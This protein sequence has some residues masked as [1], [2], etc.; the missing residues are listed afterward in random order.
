MIGYLSYSK[1]KWRYTIFGIT[2]SEKML[3]NSVLSTACMHTAIATVQYY[4]DY[5]IVSGVA[6]LDQLIGISFKSPKRKEGVVWLY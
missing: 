4:I 2:I 3:Y 1:E 5:N 6:L